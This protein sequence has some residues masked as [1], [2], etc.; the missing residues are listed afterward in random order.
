M[1]DA[2]LEMARNASVEKS[3]TID[4][5]ALR[6]YVS[7]GIYVADLGGVAV[8]HEGITLQL[9]CTTSFIPNGGD[10]T[11]EWLL[12]SCAS[13]ASVLTEVATSTYNAHWRSGPTAGASYVTGKRMFTVPLSPSRSF[14]PYLVMIGTFVDAG[15]PLDGLGEG[16]VNI[17]LNASPNTAP[18]THFPN[19][20]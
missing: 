16:N 20:I 8:G 17:A 9:D 6:L 18:H 13:E 5:I 11:V 2:L 4:L 15:T 1:H 19:A 10:V 3:Q 12:I 14:K 7:N